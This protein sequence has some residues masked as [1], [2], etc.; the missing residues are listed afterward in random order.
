MVK[1]NT[2]ASFTILLSLAVVACAAFGPC[3]CTMAASLTGDLSLVWGMYVRP[4]GPGWWECQPCPPNLASAAGA[5]IHAHWLSSVQAAVCTRRPSPVLRRLQLRTPEALQ[6]RI[7]I[8]GARGVT[9]RI[10]CQQA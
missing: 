3:T 7:P 2:R 4:M 9:E 10:V 1:C 6:C 8:V 5:T